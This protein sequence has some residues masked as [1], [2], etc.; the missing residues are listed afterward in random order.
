MQCKCANSA[1]NI[2]QQKFFPTPVALNYGSEHIDAEHI[3][4]D[5]HKASM[6]EH[7]SDNLPWVEVWTL[8]IEYGQQSIQYRKCLAG[9][10]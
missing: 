3:E 5:V 9:K 1:D 6:H 4:E 2:E 7:V 10:E 8:V